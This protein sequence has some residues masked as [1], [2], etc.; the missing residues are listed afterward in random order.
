MTIVVDVIDNVIKVY[1]DGEFI[2][3]TQKYKKLYKYKEEPYF[4]LGVGRPERPEIPNFFK[5]TIDSF[6]YYDNMLTDGQI[7]EI[8]LNNL[9]LRKYSSSHSLK[10]YYDANHIYDYKLID[11]SGNKNKAEIINCEI[12]DT[13]FESNIEI[14][15]PYRRKCTF[16][17]LKH[18]ENGFL[19]NKWKEESTRWNQLRF[20]NEILRHLSL[21]TK[22]GLSTLEFIEH[23]KTKINNITH[24]NVGI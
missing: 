12:V 7:K 20:Q 8:A 24:I 3:K 4:Y 19:G 2:G 15:I 14:K 10:M 18:E 13:E 16:K 17:S 23:G 21:I 1:Q 6:A 9:D 11:L 5:G 22:D